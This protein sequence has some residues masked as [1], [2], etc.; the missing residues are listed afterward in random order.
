MVEVHH[1]YER[2]GLILISTE[3]GVHQHMD[4][5]RDL[6]ST[7][8][9]AFLVLEAQ[10]A[11]CS[12]TTYPCSIFFCINSPNCFDFTH[13]PYETSWQDLKDRFRSCGKLITLLLMFLY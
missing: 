1:T 9:L 4:E 8:L 2:R 10:G 7:D 6:I 3:M 13:L 11:K 12:C 5:M